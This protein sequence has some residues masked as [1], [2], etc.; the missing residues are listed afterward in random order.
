ML[1]KKKILNQ[2]I[3]QFIREK[4]EN[5]KGNIKKMRSKNYQYWLTAT[6]EPFFPLPPVIKM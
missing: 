3:E 5:K 4:G 6:V 1:E 2:E